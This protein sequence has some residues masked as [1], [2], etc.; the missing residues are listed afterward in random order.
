M[1]NEEDATHKADAHLPTVSF[2]H[3]IVVRFQRD[4]TERQLADIIL[5][6]GGWPDIDSW[7]RP[8]A[9]EV[10]AHLKRIRHD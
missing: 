1:E 9:G 8:S 2:Y 10:A 5:S 7:R 3:D 6:I 4:V